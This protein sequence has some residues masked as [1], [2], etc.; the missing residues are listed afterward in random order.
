MNYH[1]PNPASDQ[2]GD[3]SLAPSE[4][5][6][7]YD[8]TGNKIR[9]WT[10]AAREKLASGLRALFRFSRAAA[11]AKLPGTDETLGA[12]GRTLPGKGIEFLEAH[13]EKAPIENQLKVAQTETE[14]L[15]QEL[16]R[17]EIR[18]K[19]ADTRGKQLAN[20]EREIELQSRL[21]QLIH[22]R[23]RS[24]L[25]NDGDE[26]IVVIGSLSVSDHALPH[27]DTVPI[28]DLGLGGRATRQLESA[29]IVTVSNLL[30]HSRESLLEMRGIGPKTVDIIEH[31]LR[32]RGLRLSG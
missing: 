18:N 29:G 11:D 30:Q 24:Y 5:F 9:R 23:A 16:L 14:Y 4:S 12:K 17:E 20:A 22:G 3:R 25:L 27:T 13:V 6:E 7:R 21:K 19:R 1:D 32:D 10:I 15:K 28:R 31:L 8:L 2:P 26:P